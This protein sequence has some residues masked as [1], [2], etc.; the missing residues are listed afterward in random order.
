[1]K[2]FEPVY[3]EL[4]NLL[5]NKLPEYI[6]KI[7]KEH[8]DGIILKA[9][10]NTTLDENCI[11]APSFIFNIE[12]TDYSEKDRIIENTVFSI[13]LEIKLQS[14]TENRIIL[15]CRYLEAIEKTLSDNE[16]WLECK[17]VN[18]SA[19]KIFIRIVF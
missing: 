18:I 12:E 7:N 16:N 13:S 19:N 10:E 15:L 5:I 1:M 3:Q 4:E 11:N 14:H 17:I 6:E 8:Y 9:F 2:N